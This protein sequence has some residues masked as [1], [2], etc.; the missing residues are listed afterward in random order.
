MAIITMSYYYDNVIMSLCH[1]VCTARNVVQISSL[2]SI[3]ALRCSNASI[4]GL[5]V[6]RRY[7][8]DTVRIDK[9]TP[10]GRAPGP[11]VW[12]SEWAHL[13]APF[14][15]ACGCWARPTW[16]PLLAEALIDRYLCTLSL[17]GLVQSSG[18]TLGMIK[19]FSYTKAREHTL[20]PM[21]GRISLP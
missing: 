11:G 20:S 2:E 1:C 10:V 7:V 3:R 18:K 21:K 5:W 4:K 19:C 6:I 17:S 8:Y 15:G 16:Y 9:R 12:L 14:L 13:A